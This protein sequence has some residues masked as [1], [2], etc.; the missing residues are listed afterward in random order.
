MYISANDFYKKQFGQKVYKISINAGT[1]CP[2]R[3]GSKGIGGCIFCSESGSGDFS[4]DNY[5][6]IPQ[7][8]EE[9][10]KLVSKKLNKNKG[11]PKYIAYF[12]S[13][14]NTYGNPDLLIEKY[15]EAAACEDIVGVAIATRPDCFNE[16]ILDGIKKLSE[17]CFVQIE[18]GLQ[19]CKEKT[20]EFINRCYENK[21]YEEAVEKIKKI[22]RNIHLVTHLIFG[23]PGEDSSDMINS[24]KYVV[25]AKTDGIKITNLYIVKNTKLEEYYYEGKVQVLSKEE[26]FE[27]L[28]KALS[29]LPD[30]IVLHRLNGDPPKKNLIAPNWPC[31]K[32]KILNEM[33][34]LGLVRN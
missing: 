5:L 10:K 1:T 25:K 31:D 12:Q 23:L 14:T 34:S 17:K 18:L 19:T 11:K 21:E 13:F 33:K 24:V 30:N 29:F 16:K 8:V 27:L 3:D 15:M 2:N 4:T 32:K 9:A 26:Y 6:S 7:Q 22:N 28:K 20:A